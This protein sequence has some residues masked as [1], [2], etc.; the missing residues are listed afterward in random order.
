MAKP[1]GCGT[2][3]IISMAPIVRSVARDTVSLDVKPLMD[4]FENFV[5]ERLGDGF[6]GK[7]FRELPQV[8]A[9]LTMAA[10]DKLGD[11]DELR[12]PQKVTEFAAFK[13]DS[14]ILL[15]FASSQPAPSFP[16]DPSLKKKTAANAASTIKPFIETAIT[17]EDR[18]P[19]IIISEDEP[20][21]VV[22]IRIT[23]QNRKGRWQATVE[24]GS[25][26]ETGLVE[27]EI[28]DDITIRIEGTYTAQ[29]ISEV[30]RQWKFRIIQSKGFSLCTHDPLDDLSPITP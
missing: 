30:P 10:T 3:Q 18:F 14:L 2:L 28:P 9:L 20:P 29:V 23:G 22:N 8:R 27:D 26:V 19:G 17:N 1:L 4:A 12:Y 6:F 16:R 11:P 15:P 5:L 7:N 24:N 13:K 21:K 25:A